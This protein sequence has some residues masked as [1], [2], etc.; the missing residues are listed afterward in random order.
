MLHVGNVYLTKFLTNLEQR[1][2]LVILLQK[3]FF[4]SDFFLNV[5]AFFL[6]VKCQIFYNTKISGTSWLILE[7][8]GQQLKSFIFQIPLMFVSFVIL[9]S[10]LFFRR[11]SEKDLNIDPFF[12]GDLKRIW[13]TSFF[14][15]FRYLK[16]TFKL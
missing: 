11:W 8:R 10:I 3:L 5:V 13:S 16:N 6:N 9:I 4:T 1:K 15:R 12:G 2:K 14:M 7:N